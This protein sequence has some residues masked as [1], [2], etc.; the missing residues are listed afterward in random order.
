MEARRARERT[1]AREKRLDTLTRDH[2]T[3]WARVDALINTRR[4]SDYDTAVEI[5]KDL[6]VVTSRAG[7]AEEFVR[8]FT[9]LRR[10]HLRKPS[11]IAR[12]D[13]ADL[14]IAPTDQ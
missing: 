3:A 4:P 2:E 12:F 13:R 5:L 7:H 6:Q 10:Q 11:L 1:L 8:R 9:L 14:G